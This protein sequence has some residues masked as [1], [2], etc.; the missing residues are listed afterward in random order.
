M[1]K[2]VHVRLDRTADLDTIAGREA[3]DGNYTVG[4]SD[5]GVITALELQLY[6]DS[7]Y[8]IDTSFGDMDMAQLWADNC[9]YIANYQ[10]LATVC[11]TNKPTTTS[12]RAPGVVQSVLVMETVIE[13]VA[14]ELNMDPMAVR[15]ANFYHI[16]NTTPYGQPIKYM[17]LPKVW[18]NLQTQANYKDTL[19]SV[20]AF[21][22][23]NRWR[24]R[25]ISI[26]PIKYGI[27]DTGYNTSCVI[28]VYPQD[29][30]L[31]A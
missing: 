6:N 4:F 14:S 15:E 9:Y 5:T 22:K 7:G 29:G 18:A 11:K 24:K 3:V 12:M 1:N 28:R 27:G 13:H 31:P 8:I 30:A 23:A 19:A 2:C 16:G 26:T 17:S 21:N 25:G 20:Q 10:S